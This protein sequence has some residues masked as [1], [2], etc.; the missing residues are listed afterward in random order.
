MEMPFLKD[1]P[2][3]LAPLHVDDKRKKMT[4]DAASSL[5]FCSSMKVVHNELAFSSSLSCKETHPSPTFFSWC[6][7]CG[8]FCVSRSEHKLG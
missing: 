4:K 1:A 8:F 3:R 2:N 5:N 7:V 6:C